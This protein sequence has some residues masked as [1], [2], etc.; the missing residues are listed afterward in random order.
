MDTKELL[1]RI[2]T[3]RRALDASVQILKNVVTILLEKEKAKRDETELSTI[4]RF[5]ARKD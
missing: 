2:Y 3:E 1:D 4:E 5:V